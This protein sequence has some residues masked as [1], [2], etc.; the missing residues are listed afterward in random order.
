MK[1]SKK[2]ISVVTILLMLAAVLAGCGGENEEASEPVT[3]KVCMAGKDIKTVC[4]ILAKELG[5]YE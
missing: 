4:V 2:I 1:I 3:L 5:Y